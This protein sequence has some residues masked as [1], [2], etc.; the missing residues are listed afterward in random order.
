MQRRLQL[1][2]DMAYMYMS[3]KK[4]L[5]QNYASTNHFYSWYCLNFI[6]IDTVHRSLLQLVLSEFYMD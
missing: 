2:K 5:M 4:H 3:S 1:H 6:W